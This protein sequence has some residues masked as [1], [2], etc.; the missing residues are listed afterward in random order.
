MAHDD[1][2]FCSNRN[3][4]TARCALVE[5]VPAVAAAVVGLWGITTPS[6]WRDESVAL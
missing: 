5:A 3:L 6:F 1:G 2:Y 4:A